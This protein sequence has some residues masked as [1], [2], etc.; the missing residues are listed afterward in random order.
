[1]K[2]EIVFYE[3]V[4][5]S[6]PVEEYLDTLTDKVVKKVIFTFELIEE[7]E[8]VPSKYLKKLTNTDDI[9]EI[10][11]KVG[12]DIYRIFCFMY[13]GS[14]VVLT[15]GYQK[16]TDKVDKK[17]IVRAEKYKKDYIERVK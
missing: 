7:L 1:M 16:K 6:S 8:I 10:R 2:R 4:D 13:K 3:T 11:V 9:W 14:L 5:G 12:S 15:N 17:E